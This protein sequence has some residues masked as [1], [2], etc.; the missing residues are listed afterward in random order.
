M[1]TFGA[2]D[3]LPRPMHVGRITLIAPRPHILPSADASR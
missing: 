1:H 3:D 2:G